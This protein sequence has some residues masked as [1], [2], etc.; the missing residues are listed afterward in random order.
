MSPWCLLLFAASRYRWQNLNR[1]SKTSNTRGGLSCFRS[2]AERNFGLGNLCKRQ[3]YKFHTGKADQFSP[4]FGNNRTI[5]NSVFQKF[6]TLH[7][8]LLAK[9]CGFY[10][11]KPNTSV[12]G[13][14]LTCFIPTSEYFHAPVAL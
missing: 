9:A 2:C 3:I 14:N 1:K 7:L 6:P 4:F 10:R 12:C 11:S 5:L 13:W 8:A